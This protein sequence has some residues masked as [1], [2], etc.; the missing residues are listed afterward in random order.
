MDTR[1]KKQA[2]PPRKRT[3]LAASAFDRFDCES[4]AYH[5]TFTGGIFAVDKFREAISLKKRTSWAAGVYPKNQSVG[6]HVHFNGNFHDDKV[7]VDVEYWKGAHRPH[8]EGPIAESIMA[9]LGEF[10]KE[11]S[12]QAMVTITFEKPSANWRARFNLPFKV[13]MDGREVIIDGISVVFPK[14]EFSAKTGFLQRYD[15]TFGATQFFERAINF[16]SFD[17]A[18]EIETMNSALTL[19]MDSIE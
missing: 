1:L 7:N 15:N 4:V 11:S 5:F 13:T 10:V 6:Y 9:W 14:N 2:S 8:V 12:Y 17:I 16:S 19:F 3:E 18:S